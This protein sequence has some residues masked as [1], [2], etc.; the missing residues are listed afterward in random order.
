MGRTVISILGDSVI[1]GLALLNSGIYNNLIF[2]FTKENKEKAGIFSKFC[3]HMFPKMTI[4]FKEIPP[5]EKPHKIV[6]FARE[7]C[8]QNN[9]FSIF[10]TA[11]AKQTILP[12]VAQA[13]TATLVELK[14]SPLRLIERENKTTTEYSVHGIEL[15]QVLA[16]RGWHFNEK[17]RKGNLHFENVE[18]SFDLNSG[19]LSFSGTSVLHR[20][21]R[22]HEIHTLSKG[23]KQRVKDQDQTTIGEILQLV[24][25]FGRNGAQYKIK[26]ALRKP[27]R[28]VL[29]PY[30][31]HEPPLDEEE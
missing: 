28:A 21:N 27:N 22:E 31:R 30:I 4:D 1:P 9:G 19:R 6:E 20:E 25:D 8:T 5:M 3:Q 18:P 11:G 2:F 13:P 7:F 15:N 16:T 12:F 17:L 23:E 29:P 14:H 10:I 26:G 24:T